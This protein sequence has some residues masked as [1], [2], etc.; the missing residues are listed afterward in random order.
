MEENNLTSIDSY[1]ELDCRPSY[2]VKILDGEI[3]LT[4]SDIVKLSKFFQ[5][6]PSMFV[7]DSYE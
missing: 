1:D 6:N 4:L 7:P 3:K 5:I 2:V